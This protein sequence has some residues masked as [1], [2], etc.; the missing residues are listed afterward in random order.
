M[1]AVV[2]VLEGQRRWKQCRPKLEIKHIR[3]VHCA[4]VEC[5][6][7]WLM[8]GEQHWREFSWGRF[9][10]KQHWQLLLGAPGHTTR[11][12][13]LLGAK[14]IATRSNVRY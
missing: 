2:V 14:S 1:V 4:A 10:A 9:V 8:E 3:K 6:I 12:K 13:K 7:D 5:D 11:S